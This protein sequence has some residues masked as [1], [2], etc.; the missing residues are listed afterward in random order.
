MTDVWRKYIPDELPDGRSW[1]K[2]SLTKISCYTVYTAVKKPK[3]KGI[4]KSCSLPYG[5]SSATKLTLLDRPFFCIAFSLSCKKQW[6]TRVHPGLRMHLTV[7][8]CS[9]VIYAPFVIKYVLNVFVWI[10]QDGGKYSLCPP[11]FRSGRTCKTPL[12]RR[13]PSGIR[14]TRWSNRQIVQYRTILNT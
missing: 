10:A 11:P 1:R 14:I 9:T 3:Y 13:K 6:T 4:S 5:W 2:F 12:P 7:R 8:S